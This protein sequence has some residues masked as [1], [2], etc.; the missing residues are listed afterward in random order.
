MALL[1]IFKLPEG[2]IEAQG[3]GAGEIE[4]ALVG[5]LGDAEDSGGVL[6]EE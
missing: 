1:P 3:D 2:F 5:G 4:A 6:V